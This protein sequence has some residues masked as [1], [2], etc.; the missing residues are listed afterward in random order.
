MARDRCGVLVLLPALNNKC[1]VSQYH[2]MLS[3]ASGCTKSRLQGVSGYSNKNA[4]A[5]PYLFDLIRRCD[6]FAALLCAKI[7]SAQGV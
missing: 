2:V 6:S 4:S 3:V 7:F 5:I 1:D